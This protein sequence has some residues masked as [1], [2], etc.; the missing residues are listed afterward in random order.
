[1]I[2]DCLSELRDLRDL[3]NSVSWPSSVQVEVRA[4]SRGDRVIRRR[5]A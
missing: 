1:M 3:R 2:N 4:D 5:L